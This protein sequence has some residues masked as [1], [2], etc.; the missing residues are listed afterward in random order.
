VTDLRRPEESAVNEHP[1][2]TGAAGSGP[3]VLVVVGTDAHPFDRL[4]EWLERWYA[5]RPDRPRLIVQHGSSRTPLLPGARAYLGHDELELAMRGALVVVSH[6]GPATI[7]EARRS[8]HLPIVVPRDPARAEHVD[9]HQLLFARR[10]ARLGAIRLCES[11]RVFAAALDSGLAEPAAFALDGDAA[12][13]WVARAEA[14]AR[15]GRI[16]EDLVRAR[17]RRHGRRRRG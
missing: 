2:G 13:G 14:A 4:V 6:G 8:G 1:D 7:S 11:E 3:A 16:V 9:D 17:Q 15:V 5:A 10:L 12:N